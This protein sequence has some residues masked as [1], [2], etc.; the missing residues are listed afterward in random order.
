MGTASQRKAWNQAMGLA[1]EGTRGSDR[2][3]ATRRD[4]AR[5][6][7]LY[8]SSSAIGGDGAANAAEERD[9]RVAIHMDMLEDVKDT[10]GGVEDGDDDDDDDEYDE[11]SELD[12]DDEKG[13]SMAKKA[14]AK[15][16]RKRKSAGAA[17]NST[18]PK[19]LRPRSLASILIEEA[20]RSDSV[21]KQ[22]VDASVRRL[23]SDT[24]TTNTTITTTRQ[25]YPQ[26][27]FCPV[28]GLFGSYTEP[29]SGI[30]Y[31]TLSALEQIRERAPPWMNVGNGGGSAGYWEAMKSLRSDL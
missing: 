15:K 5:K 16:K 13:N 11:F 24:S 14:P 28:T 19:Y 27:K 29:K 30:P 9:Y 21:A 6:S 12:E 31:A 1:P 2:R 26:R 25:P 7:S 8:A 3:K 10:T 22:Y 17:N 23:S 20:N 18:L 4:K